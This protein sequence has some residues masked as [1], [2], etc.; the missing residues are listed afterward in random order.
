VLYSS[1][2]HF[3]VSDEELGV[4]LELLGASLDEDIAS[5]LELG[6]RDDELLEIA[7]LD[8][9]GSAELEV[10]AEGEELL[11]GVLEDERV[12]DGLLGGDSGEG[13]LELLLFEEQ[14]MV[15][16]RARVE[17]NF[18]MGG[19][20][21]VGFLI[22]WLILFLYYAPRERFYYMGFSRKEY[23]YAE[24]TPKTE[25]RSAYFGFYFQKSLC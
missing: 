14:D 18:L 16:D 17:R 24:K 3:G 2:P 1:P 21:L 10:G 13:S 19:S 6:A 9:E 7:S 12:A 22:G 11:C 25:V 8:E 4:E 20:P 23:N 5:E 15:R